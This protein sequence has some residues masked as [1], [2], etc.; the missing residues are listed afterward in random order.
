[1]KVNSKLKIATS[2]TL[3]LTLSLLLATYFNFPSANTQTTTTR[4]SIH[5][6]RIEV[7]DPNVEVTNETPTEPFVITVNVSNVV[8]L[9]A[10]QVHIEYDPS[11]VNCTDAWLPEGHVFE[12]KN[13]MPVNYTTEHSRIRV[14][15]QTNIDLKNPANNTSWL[16][17]HYYEW[18]TNKTPGEWKATHHPRNMTGWID[19]DD[20]GTL[21]V[22]DVVELETEHITW[23]YYICSMRTLDGTIELYLEF[24]YV[25]YGCS[26]LGPAEPTFTG[27]GTLCQI[28]FEGIG[29][30]TSALNL[31]K[32]DCYLC[33]LVDSTITEMSFEVDN[34]VV[35]VLGF[36]VESSKI[37][38]SASPTE[39]Q[40]GENVTFTGE[41][42]P[43]R[44]NV[45][46]TIKYRENG[47]NKTLAVVKTDEAGKFVYVWHTNRTGVF[48]FRASWEGDE[49]TLPAESE[50]VTVTVGEAAFDPTLYIVVGGVAAIVV[51]AVVVYFKKFR[52]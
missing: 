43:I 47:E 4:I 28:Q 8:D 49:R 24:G 44:S 15:N 51:V 30:G 35:E 11:K 36:S 45:D 1:M 26:L 27:N 31:T 7:G 48:N 22:G 41:I 21:T 18:P 39:V 10:W 42:T 29:V 52:G 3:I 2:L 5:P 40:V 32:T 16:F 37:T 13:I 50:E 19:K 20:S 38:L 46:V 33:D 9:F 12:G 34:A 14:K 25:L 6:S 17:T 23:T